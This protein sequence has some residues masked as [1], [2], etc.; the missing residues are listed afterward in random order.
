[1]SLPLTIGSV[2]IYLAVPAGILALGTRIKLIRKVNPVIICYVLGLLVGNV[3]I[4]P[5][6]FAALQDQLSTVVVALSIPLLLF[7]VNISRWSRISIRAI[8]ALG[9]AAVSVAIAATVSHLL[10]GRFIPDS[11]RIAGMMVGL[12]TGGTPN[13]AAISTALNVASEP[14]LAVHTADTILGGVYLLFVITI[15]KPLLSRILKPFQKDESVALEEIEPAATAHFGDI[16]RKPYRLQS[17]AAFGLSVLVVGISL[18]ISMLVPPDWETVVV[19]LCLTTLAIAASLVP[20]VRE[21]KTSFRMAEYL[22]L[23]FCLVVGSMANIERLLHTPP[24]L[25]SFVALTLFG[26]L[27]LHIVLCK[28][29]GIDVDTMIVTSTAAICSPPFVGM[30]AVAIR[31][32]AVISAGITAGIIGYAV[33]NYLGV[34]IAL[35]LERL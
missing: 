4:L 11:P 2:L 10:F 3:G 25:L 23:V 31:N 32:R 21:L 30:A 7:S 1:M 18:G 28:I 24:Q 8:V 15:A 19:L 26:S 20:R 14:Y 29:A 16:F 9:L 17:L 34:F 33:G 22:V 27:F 12:Y 6:S 35:V 5:E 13:L